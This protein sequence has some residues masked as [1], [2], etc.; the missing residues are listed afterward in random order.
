MENKD[1]EE[2]IELEKFYS[3]TTIGGFGQDWFCR[4][5]FDQEDCL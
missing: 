5:I 3:C 1:K 4:P 2:Q